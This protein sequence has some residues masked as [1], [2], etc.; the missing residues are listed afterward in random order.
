MA[1]KLLIGHVAAP[2]KCTPLSERTEITHLN[3]VFRHTIG[4][5]YPSFRVM[6][7]Q[8]TGGEDETSLRTHTFY[9]VEFRE[10]RTPHH[11]LLVFYPHIV[12]QKFSVIEKS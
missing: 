9:V 8:R 3:P 5:L 12:L 11:W 7:K 4:Y 6:G 2:V 1:R 10:E